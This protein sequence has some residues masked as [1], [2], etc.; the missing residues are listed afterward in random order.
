MKEIKVNAPFFTFYAYTKNQTTIVCP[1]CDFKK[2][3]D[4]TPYKTVNRALEVKC[5]CG[6]AFKCVIEF[7]KCYRKKVN[8]SG[9]HFSEKTRKR[10]ILRVEE[11]SMGGL[12]FSS[13]DP[14][15]LGKGDILEV[16]FQLD[17]PN[18]TEIIKRA[19]VL[20]VK[21]LM[22]AIKFTDKNEWD[23]Q[24]GFYMMP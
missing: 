1:S 5:I 9:E 16:N 10:G 24:L 15:N 12:R 23:K 19:V 17:D 11:I 20:R 22:V 13:L 7:R 14:H 4:A 2:K 6:E 18:K 21:D 3:I 8:L